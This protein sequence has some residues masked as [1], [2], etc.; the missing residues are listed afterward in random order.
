MSSQK[1]NAEYEY[2]LIIYNMI[3]SLLENTT[4]TSEMKLLLLKKKKDAYKLL[5]ISGH[6]YKYMNQISKMTPFSFHQICLE[7]LNTTDVLQTHIMFE[8]ISLLPE[9]II[10][11]IG[12]YSHAVI[13]QKKLVRIEFYN[14]WFKTNTDRIL[15][16]LKKWKKRHLGFVLNKIKSD[17]NPSYNNCKIGSSSYK[18]GE[19]ILF[20]SKIETLVEQI[21]VRSNQ[22]K[23]SLLLAIEKYDSKIV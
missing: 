16:M 21:G 5:Q 6:N 7:N 15:N 8:H 3:C 18:K 13:N 2:N 19:I 11:L 4:N 23:Y 1:I 10:K 22:E 12:Q 17:S 20:R 14:K 9:D